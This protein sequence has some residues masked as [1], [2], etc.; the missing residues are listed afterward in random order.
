MQKQNKHSVKGN[1][2]LKGWSTLEYI[3][4]AVLIASIVGALLGVFKTKITTAI[5]DQVD[6]NINSAQ[7]AFNN[8]SK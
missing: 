7:D 5:N 4:G 2:N 6:I 1:K 8:N 3:I